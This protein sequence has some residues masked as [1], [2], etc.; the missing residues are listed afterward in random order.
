MGSLSNLCA[1]FALACL[2]WRYISK[3][4]VLMS[5]KKDETAVHFFDPALLVLVMFGVSKLEVFHV[6]RIS[7][8]VNFL[9]ECFG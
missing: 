7:V 8:A 9:S 4:T 6:A 5:P 3:Y 1:A 2:G